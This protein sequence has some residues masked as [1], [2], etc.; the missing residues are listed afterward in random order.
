MREMENQLRAARQEI[1]ELR[2]R[3]EAMSKEK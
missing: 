3:L 1:Q 2:K